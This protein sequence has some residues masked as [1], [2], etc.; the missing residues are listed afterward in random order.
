MSDSCDFYFWDVQHGHACYI[1]T[2]NNRHIVIDL[3]TGDYSDNDSEFSPLLYLKSAM[4]VERLDYVIITHPHLDHIDD[5]LNLDALS[6]RVLSR[7][8][9][10]SRDDILANVRDADRDKFEKYCD[11]DLSFRHPV[12]DANDIYNPE[13][14]GDLRIRSFTPTG[15]PKTNFNDHS[16]VSIFTFAKLKVVIPGD[17]ER[18]SF[19][20]LLN[21]DDFKS[22][23]INADVLLAPHHGRESGY[24]SEF[25]DLVNPK[26]TIV[27]DGRHCDTS[28]N[29]RYSA[30]SS[31]WK[32]HYRSDKSS[33][34]RRCL[35][36][37]SDGHIQVSIGWNSENN[38][39]SVTAS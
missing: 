14:W 35:T 36:T 22:E 34:K 32:V 12:D 21:D 28:A 31:G 39:L 26:I 38:F 15:C 19:E 7:P 5:I 8:R 1:N 2:P 10:L 3:G 6:P 25:V 30:K 13:N 16:I 9:H 11:M 4:N 37:N 24:Y 18:C 27:S 20:E 29:N 33:E 23:V 17:N